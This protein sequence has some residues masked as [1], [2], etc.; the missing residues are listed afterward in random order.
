[1]EK[2]YTADSVKTCTSVNL[3]YRVRLLQ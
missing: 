1:M 2:I 3:R